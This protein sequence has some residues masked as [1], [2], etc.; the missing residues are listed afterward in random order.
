MRS[1]AHDVRAL[2]EELH[3]ASSWEN[4]ARRA[5]DASDSSNVLAITLSHN[6]LAAGQLVLAKQ[7]WR[8]RSRRRR[9]GGRNSGEHFATIANQVRVVLDADRVGVETS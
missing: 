4:S 3:R 1:H 7:R 2:R 9:L 8:R 5:A 6:K